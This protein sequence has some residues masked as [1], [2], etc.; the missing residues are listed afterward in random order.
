M[1]IKISG[2]KNRLVPGSFLYNK[3]INKKNSLKS[4]LNEIEKS[5]NIKKKNKR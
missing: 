2:I 3:W 5:F 4:N 1:N